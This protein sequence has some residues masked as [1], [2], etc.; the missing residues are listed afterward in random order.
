MKDTYNVDKDAL[1]KAIVAFAKRYN[2]QEN[3]K[4]LT[5]I[6]RTLL[7]VANTVELWQE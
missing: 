2:L 1:V 7:N 5:A 4:E 6:E 3:R